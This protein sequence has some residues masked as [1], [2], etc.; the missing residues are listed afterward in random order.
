MKMVL[1]R[2]RCPNC[3]GSLSYTDL[4]PRWWAYEAFFPEVKMPLVGICAL[5]I[6]TGLLLALIHPV[7]AVLG[8]LGV[9]AWVTF[10]YFAPLQCDSCHAYFISGHFR[11]GLGARVPWSSQDSRK[12]IL[13][14]LIAC[15]V[16]LGVF[17]VIQAAVSWHASTCAA[18]CEASGLQMQNTKRIFD[19]TCTSAHS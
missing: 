19:C 18:N 3:G 7:L 6:I 10:Y 4:R 14:T 17:G 9:G 2:Y 11:H 15:A 13:N 1:G 5:T 16:I 12:L 8:V